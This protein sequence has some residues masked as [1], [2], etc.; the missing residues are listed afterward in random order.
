MKKLL[1]VFDKI[2]EIMIFLAGMILIF[3]MLSVC[4]EVILRY[5]INRPQ[6]WVTEV[7]ECLLLYITFLGSAWLLREEGH[8][9]VD[10]V[11][12]RLRPSIKAFLGIVGSVIGVFTAVILTIYGFGVT[13]SYFQ[14][15]I[16]TPSAMEIPVAAI[17][18]IIPI[19]SMILSVQFIRR[20]VTFTAGFLIELR[21]STS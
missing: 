6:V 16:Y 17:I 3:I 10:I 19:G 2:I 9:K 4:L 14:R 15:G 1:D 13:W 8:V 11:L 12:N 21:K 20:A 5:S 7:T 18:V